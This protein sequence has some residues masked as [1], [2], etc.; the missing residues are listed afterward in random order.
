ML[1]NFYFY[2]ILI[3]SLFV[4]L[5]VVSSSSLCLASSSLRL[6]LLLNHHPEPSLVDIEKHSLSL[7]P[8]T[9]WYWKCSEC[10][11]PRG[12]PQ[13]PMTRPAFPPTAS[14]VP[15]FPPIMPDKLL[16]WSFLACSTFQSFAHFLLICD[17]RSSIWLS[18]F[19]SLS[20][21]E[22]LMIL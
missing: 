16:S 7:K 6:K 5:S 8:P 14:L 1:C 17:S 9:T 3:T 21:S 2:F 13:I 11:T 4:L 19:V 22:Y 18:I 20:G 12:D 10:Q 15:S